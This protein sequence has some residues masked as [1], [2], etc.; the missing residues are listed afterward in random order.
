MAQK[1]P[2]L[3]RKGLPSTVFTDHKEFIL[4]RGFVRS[5]KA[6]FPKSVSDIP[7]SFLYF[8]RRSRAAFS[9]S[10][11]A[12][13]FIGMAPFP[14]MIAVKN[15]HAYLFGTS[16]DMK[17]NLAYPKGQGQPGGHGPGVSANTPAAR[18]EALALRQSAPMTRP[19]RFGPRVAR[20]PQ[21]WHGGEANALGR[22]LDQGAKHEG[23]R[24]GPLRTVGLRNS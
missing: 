19:V 16:L 1:S 9:M 15:L 4:L 6:F 21:R 24:K 12:C 3:S 5:G 23:Q 18:R 2:S 8:K 14:A 11:M 20:V 13:S 22:R 10:K 7:D 17:N